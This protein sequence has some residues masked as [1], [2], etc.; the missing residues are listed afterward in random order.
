MTDPTLTTVD[1][2]LDTTV[3]TAADR[4]LSQLGQPLRSKPFVRTI[5]PR[6][7]VGQ[8]TGPARGA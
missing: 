6:L 1:Q 5:E 3:T 8:S 2:N 4:I 7:V